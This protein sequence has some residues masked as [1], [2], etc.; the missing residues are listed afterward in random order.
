ME[1]KIRQLLDNI[2]ELEGLLHLSLKRDDLHED[3][4]RLVAKKGKEIAKW[5]EELENTT[6]IHSNTEIKPSDAEINVPIY[7]FPSESEIPE[8]QNS[9]HDVNDSFVQ[10]DSISDY[11]YSLEESV[12]SSIPVE[13]ESNGK[14]VFSINDK[15]RF[16][17]ELFS[18][19]NVEFN[20]TLAL[21]ASMENYEEAEDYFINEL[22]W[23]SQNPVVVEFLLKIKNYFN[24]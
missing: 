12:P 19:S 18:D 22:H 24:E 16:R 7:D 15:F 9:N 23:D 14:L 21:V 17:K 20:N 8:I 13:K 11:V 3:F 10:L 5:C 2:Y 4:M 6:C 1:N